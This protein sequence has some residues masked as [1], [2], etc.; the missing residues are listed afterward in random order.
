MIS[1]SKTK[2]ARSNL[3]IVFTESNSSDP[4]CPVTQFSTSDAE[5]GKKAPA[6]KLKNVLLF[7][8][9]FLD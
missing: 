6:K 2:K 4:L 8:H 1:Y 3:I 9:S 5:I 7:L